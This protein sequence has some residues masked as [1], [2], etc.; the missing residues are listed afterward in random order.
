MYMAIVWSSSYEVGNPQID[1]QHKQ[2]IGMIGDFVNACTSRKAVQE[3]EHALV[4]LADY[5]SQHFAFEEKWQLSINYPDYPRHKQ[6]HEE[7]KAKVG[8]LVAKLKK[9][10][11]SDVIA[12]QVNTAVG[13]WLISHI[14]REDTKIVAFA[15]K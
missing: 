2:L 12:L 8:S 3:L 1:S 13:E 9:E 15:K 11:P 4:F 7:F 14:R 5:T 10:G 6:I